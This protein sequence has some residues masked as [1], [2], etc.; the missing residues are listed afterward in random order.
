MNARLRLSNIVTRLTAQLAVGPKIGSVYDRDYIEAYGKNLPEIWVSGQRLT[1]IDDGRGLSSQMRQYCHADLAI[2]VMMARFPEGV[3]DPETAFAALCDSVAAALIGWTP[4]NAVE[5][6]A[7]QSS[8][9]GES[10]QSMIYSDLVFRT[11]TIHLY[12]ITP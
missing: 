6:F 7:W 4:P 8:M 5:S 12:P 10:N 3:A 9:D 1:S 2:R 11:R